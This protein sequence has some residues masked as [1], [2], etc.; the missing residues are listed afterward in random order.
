L[1]TVAPADKFGEDAGGGSGAAPALPELAATDG[2]DVAL[3][4]GDPGRVSWGVVGSQSFMIL[5]LPLVATQRVPVTHVRSLHAV[6][7]ATVTVPKASFLMKTRLIG[8]R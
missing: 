1:A 6:C 8:E 2:L 4:R 5:G 3:T 7:Y